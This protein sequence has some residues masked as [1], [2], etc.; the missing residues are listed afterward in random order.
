MAYHGEMQRVA[1]PKMVGNGSPTLRTKRR[2]EY[3]AANPEKERLWRNNWA[4]RNRH[5]QQANSHTSTLRVRY[6][7]QAEKISPKELAQWILPRRGQPCPYC[8]SVAMHIDHRV[9]LSRG[10]EHSFDNLQMIC[11]ICNRAKGASTEEE[12]LGWISALKALDD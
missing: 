1:K 11:E 3:R 10:G 8:K 4:E 6:P 5:V 9:P 12:F 7:K 2:A